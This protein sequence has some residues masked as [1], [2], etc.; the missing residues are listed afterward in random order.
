MHTAAKGLKDEMS[1]WLMC[2]WKYFNIRQ[3]VSNSIEQRLIDG[4]FG[5]IFFIGKSIMK[6]SGMR[7]ILI[8]IIV[9]DMWS[10]IFNRAEDGG[11]NYDCIF[12][13]PSLM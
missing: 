5:L 6:A 8:E 1:S 9:M 13:Y 3:P 2:G 12:M 10:I 7:Q 4:A 11:F